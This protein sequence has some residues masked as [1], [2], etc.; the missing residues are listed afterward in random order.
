MALLNPNIGAAAVDREATDWAATAALPASL[1]KD[2]DQTAG[3]DDP[4]QTETTQGQGGGPESSAQATRQTQ[5]Q[6]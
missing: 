3:R 5:V 4:D 2:L 1:H 6:A